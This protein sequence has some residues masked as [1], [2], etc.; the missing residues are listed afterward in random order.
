M[1]TPK[2]RNLNVKIILKDDDTVEV[3]Q[4]SEWEPTITVTTEGTDK[5]I[6]IQGKIEEMRGYGELF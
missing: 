1:G 3:K 2:Y 6:V 5:I 4:F